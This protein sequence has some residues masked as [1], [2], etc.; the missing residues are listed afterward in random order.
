MSKPTLS[1][2]AAGMANLQGLAIEPD[3]EFIVGGVHYPCFKLVACILA[4]Y[5]QTAFRED[6]SLSSVTLDVPDPDHYFELVLGLT[7]GKPCKVTEGNFLFIQ[8]VGELLQNER[9]EKMAV[10]EEF[11]EPTESNCVVMLTKRDALKM[12]TGAWMDFVAA[13]FDS[14]AGQEGMKGLSIEL[15]ENVVGSPAFRFTDRTFDIL[16]A[17]AAEREDL[18]PLVK[19][20]GLR[21]F[22]EL[23]KE[24]LQ[25]FTQT[26]DDDDLPE[27]SG[28]LLASLVRIRQK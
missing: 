6:P 24:Q 25:A 21:H 19:Q 1:L 22:G 4:P 9:I 10:M 23:T 5:L 15:M 14:V 3:F 26:I 7:Y 28:V 11:K 27:A 13:N 2:S 12:P 16:M 20:V 8:K 17:L 18:L